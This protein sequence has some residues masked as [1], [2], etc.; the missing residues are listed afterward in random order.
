MKT[1]HRPL[2]SVVFSFRNEGDVLPELLRRLRGVLD[3]LAVDYELIFVNDASMDNSLEVLLEHAKNDKHIK[4]VN[5]SNC[6]GVNPCFMAGIRYAR[7]DAVVTMD[8]DLQDPPELLPE[9]IE[10]WREGADVVYTTRRTREGES[11]FKMWLT[12]WGYK[13]WR[14]GSAVEVPDQ[15]GMYKLMSRRVVDII[16]KIDEPDPFL[17][18]LITWAGFKQVQVSYNRKPRY[19]GETHYPLLGTGPAKEFTRGLTSFS[20]LPMAAAVVLGALVM[21]AA[22]LAFLIVLL[23]KCFGAAIQWVYAVLAALGFLGGLQLFALGVFGLYIHRIHNQVR[24]R[25][26]YIVESTVGFD[27]E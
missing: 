25:P 27:D 10:K 23:L 11:R 20:V 17:R 18:G 2:V 15:S 7:G 19:A 4:I 3:P 9:L 1:E 24:S 21:L 12:K 14:W 22:L 6:F 5:M 13:L 8:T 16:A 26:E